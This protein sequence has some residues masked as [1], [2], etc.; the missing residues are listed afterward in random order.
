MY[1]VFCF[2]GVCVILSEY[3]KEVGLVIVFLVFF[4]MLNFKY[5]KFLKSKVRVCLNSYKKFL[6]FGID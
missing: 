4:L 1:I 2:Y 3:E 6:C 5:S